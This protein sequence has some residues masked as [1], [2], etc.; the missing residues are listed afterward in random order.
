MRWPYRDKRIEWDE[1]KNTQL[2]RTRGVSFNDVAL[3]VE[4]E[5]SILDIFPHPNQE[6]YPHQI[7]LVLNIRNYACVIPF[8]ED[9]EKVFFKT[10]YKSRKFH[11]I[12]LA[13]DKN[14]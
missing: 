10:V 12:Y 1:E 13:K 3:A 11:H 6:V 7:I 5:G 14:V 2:M 4:E 9:K 8:V